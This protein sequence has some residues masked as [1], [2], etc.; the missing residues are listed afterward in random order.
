MI[1]PTIITRFTVRP[2]VSAVCSG[3]GGAGPMVPT[4][5]IHPMSKRIPVPTISAANVVNM[6]FCIFHIPSVKIA[7]VDFDVYLNL[8]DEHSLPR[9]FCM[10]RLLTRPSLLL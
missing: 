3:G 4:P 9:S 6:F 2:K 8:D 5:P 7:Q 1:T 10:M